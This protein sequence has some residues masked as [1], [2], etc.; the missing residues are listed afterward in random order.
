MQPFRYLPV[1]AETD[2]VAAAHADAEAAYLAGGTSLL[3]LM[4]LDVLTPRQLIDVNALP[5][6]QIDLRPDGIRIGAM[7]R[8]SDVAYHPEVMRRYPLLAEAVL[9]GASP[10]IRNM[11]SVGGN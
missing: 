9:A 3:D 4:K 5:L 10:Q 1:A 2:A 8:N 6:A 11:A 7:V